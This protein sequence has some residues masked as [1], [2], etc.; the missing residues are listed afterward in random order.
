[1]SPI[2]SPEVRAYGNAIARKFI[3]CAQRPAHHGPVLAIVQLDL[4]E[5]RKGVEFEKS[6]RRLTL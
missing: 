6:I 5:A 2:L 3:Y 4:C 1:L